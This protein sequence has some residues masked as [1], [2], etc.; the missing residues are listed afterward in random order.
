MTRI[1]KEL[2]VEDHYLGRPA[3]A[4]DKIVSRRLE[5]LYELL[6]EFY[7]TRANLLEIGCGNGA[8]LSLVAQ[9][10]N[11]CLGVDINDDHQQEFEQLNEQNTNCSF[12]V[13]N[14]EEEVVSGN[15]NRLMSFEVIEHLLNENSVKNYYKSLQSN[16]LVAISVPNKWWIFEIHGAK[17][18]GFRHKRVPLL[19]W[20]PRFIHE[21][22]ANARIYSKSRIR[23]LMQNAGFEI[24]GVD[25]VTAPLDVLK[26]SAFKRF[27]VKHFFGKKSTH[28]P[29]MAV[30]I[31]LTAKKK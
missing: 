18:P 9:R 16:S 10:F 31:L 12:K 21:P 4:T 23:K 13:H 11:N 15:F 17:I 6:P 24:I 25:Y 7:D 19:S 30:S 2:F 1:D 26:D 14:I 29:F 5:L 20:M 27:M 8:S 3:D 22:L 28:I